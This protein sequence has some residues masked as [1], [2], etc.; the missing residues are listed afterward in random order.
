MKVLSTTSFTPR[1]R[2]SAATAATSVSAIMGLVGVST[3]ISF[4]FG[5]NARSKPA[6]SAAPT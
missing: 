1:G 5:R 6:I 4:V 2:A 3:K